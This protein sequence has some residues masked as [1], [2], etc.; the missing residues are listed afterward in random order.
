[1]SSLL[2]RSAPLAICLAALFVAACGGAPASGNGVATLDPNTGSAASAAPATRPED[3]REAMLAHS[4]CMRDHGVTN[5]PDP[6]FGEGDVRISISGAEGIEPN[7]PT[8]QAAEQACESLRPTAPEGGTGPSKERYE[9][10]LKF[11]Q[12]MRS[13]G[14]PDF[15]DPQMSGGGIT[16][17]QGGPGT[18]GS[19]TDPNSPTMQAAMEACQA[20]LPGGSRQIGSSDGKP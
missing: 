18:E 17:R 16:V 10:A 4:Q 3:P 12:C 20:L 15:P 19:G 11:A 9:E 5:F 2:Q 6:E 7:S 1:M 8:M 13:H 14:V